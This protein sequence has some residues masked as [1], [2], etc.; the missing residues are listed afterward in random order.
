MTYVSSG[1]TRGGGR[2]VKPPPLLVFLLLY[3]GIRHTY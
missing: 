2:G 1:C 3:V